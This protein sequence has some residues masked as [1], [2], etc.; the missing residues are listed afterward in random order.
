[1][2]RA[3]VEI[4]W[5]LLKIVEEPDGDR[6]EACWG[7]LNIKA[8]RRR[9]PRHPAPGGSEPRP[10]PTDPFQAAVRRTDD[11]MA[12]LQACFIV[13]CVAV[14][15]FGVS[16]L[17]AGKPFWAGFWGVSSF[18]TGAT[19]LGLLM[20]VFA[21]GFRRRW[22]STELAAADAQREARREV[23]SEHTEAM[24]ELTASIAHEIR[25]PITAAKSLVQQM[26]EDPNSVEN[27]EFAS[28][29]LEE[30][31]RV[32]RSV[33]HL[34]RFARDEQI[35]LRDMQLADA[36][37]SAVEGVRDRA[38]QVGVAVHADL[39]TPGEISGDAEKL[40]RVMLN[41]LGNAIDAL[42]QGGTSSPALSVEMGE[43]LAA[44]DVW[45][46]V[47][48]NGPGIEPGR[49]PK[50]FSPFQTSK[51][52]GTGLGLP[53]CR[54]I[55]EGHA[56]TIDATSVPGEGAEFVLTFPKRAALAVV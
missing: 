44:T 15:L 56:G 12:N 3:R 33:S 22:L 23:A 2:S 9:A 6:I 35:Q 26:G 39:G 5:G 54:K 36:V 17:S 14:A 19:S 47:R 31:E 24:Q 52:T 4:G 10:L 16:L 55:V 40:R 38:A 50:I 42:E 34:L 37:A 25:N 13:G 7:L 30:L 27:I 28:V 51:E 49:L 11:R 43:N 53:I 20:G 32:E 21:E 41:L 18:V 46:R 1:M 45:I 29:A 8:G 48:D